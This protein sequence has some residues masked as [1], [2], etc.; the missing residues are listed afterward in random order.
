M[1][2]QKDVRR[3]HFIIPEVKLYNAAFTLYGY[4]NPPS[5]PALYN[6]QL[7]FIT[8]NKTKK[9]ILFFMLAFCKVREFMEIILR[10]P[11][12]QNN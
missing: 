3:G 2:N 4:P 11:N 6:I 8:V 7:A 12:C 9:I 5:T 1:A 10:Q